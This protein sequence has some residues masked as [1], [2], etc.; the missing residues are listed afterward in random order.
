[1]RELLDAVDPSAPF[2]LVGA[3]TF[4]L[5]ATTIF[6]LMGVPRGRRPM[7]KEWCGHRADARVGSP[8]PAEQVDHAENM[9][10]YRRYLRALVARQG[11]AAPTT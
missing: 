5:P 9:V 3:L 6:T 7:L 11:G 2:D 1:M 10:A 4:P 8:G